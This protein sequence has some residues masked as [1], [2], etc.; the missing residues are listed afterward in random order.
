M[1]K[2]PTPF[3]QYIAASRYARYR[4]DLGRRETWD[5]TV[6]RYIEF[7]RAKFPGTRGIPWEEL[8]S[9]ILNL[10]IMPSMRCLMTA[11]PALARDAVAGYNCAYVAVDNTRVFD[12]IMY[13]LLCGTGVGYS[14]ERQY[15]AK[16]PEVAEEF[17]DVDTEI[18]VRDSKIGWASALRQL[19]ALLY[20]GNVP[21]WDLS[22][23]RPAGARLKTFGGRAS[24]PEPLDDLFKYVV[25]TF[26]GA[27]GRKLNSLEVHDLVCKI[28]T[29][30][31]VGGVRR[32]ALIC[33][34]NLTD[35]RMRK[36]KSGEWYPTQPQRSLA[37][38]SVAY[39]E[40]PDMGMFMREWQ[41]LY[42]SKSGERG[43]FVR[44]AVRAMLP[45]RRDPDHE[46]GC[47][48]CSEIILRSKQ[49]C[50]L[51][52]IVV[53][54]GDTDSMLKRKAELAAILGTLQST[55]TDFRYLSSAWKKNTEE[56]RL[57]GVSATGI[58]DVP[59]MAFYDWQWLK[60]VTVRTNE[61]YAKL[62]GIPAAAAVTCV[63]PSG[64]VSQLVDCSSGMH[65]RY[66]RYYIRRVRGDKHDPLCGALIEAGVPHETDLHNPGAWVF[67]FPMK[68]PEYA[69]VVDEV[70]AVVQLE[71][72]LHLQ[73]TWCEHK[74]SVSIYVRE[75]EWLSVGAWVYDH[76]D[77][78][79]G[80]SFFPH[81]DHIYPQAPYEKITKD[82]Y[83]AML[84]TFPKE[85][86][87]TVAEETDTTTSSQELACSAATGCEL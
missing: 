43:I 26:R 40:K 67:S 17:N 69:T 66:S 16:L 13:I 47:N 58:M 79:S 19:I 10:D 21:R 15:I 22:R 33:L 28:G 74:P 57:L 85:I 23:I 31:V 34:S 4:D 65:P 25:R 32:A 24:G 46:W 35:E 55:L 36:A 20:Q 30:V 77:K 45:E 86:N 78:M 81:E 11:G 63:K 62:L 18:H 75:H 27:K 71:Q 44:Y 12:E 76:F 3:Q 60:D 1:T 51:S 64:T 83:E 2:L 49:F 29:A 80:V 50:N 37:N 41:S 52:E 6:D 38:N 39:T 7:F 9:G 54:P 48:P 70:S 5:E 53:R 42:E 87:L 68:S 84:A 14:V 82:A 59:G 56:E 61:K 73:E 72:W 8:R